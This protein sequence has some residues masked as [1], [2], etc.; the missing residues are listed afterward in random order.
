MLTVAIYTAPEARDISVKPD[1]QGGFV[2]MWKG[3]RRK[4]RPIGRGT[5]WQAAIADLRRKEK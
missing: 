1:P 5:T 3:D 4:P 2:A